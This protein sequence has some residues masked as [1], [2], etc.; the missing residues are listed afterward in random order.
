[1]NDTTKPEELLESV[2]ETSAWSG[3][4]VSWWYAQTAANACPHLKLGKYVKFRRSEVRAWLE[5]HRRGPGVNE[6]K[7][8]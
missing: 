3:L 1:M 2:G 4:P 7:G 6:R 8:R 5:Q